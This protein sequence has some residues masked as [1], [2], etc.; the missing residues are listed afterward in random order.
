MIPILHVII[1]VMDILV[2]ETRRKFTCYFVG[3]YFVEHY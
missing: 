2:S 1:C 3:Y